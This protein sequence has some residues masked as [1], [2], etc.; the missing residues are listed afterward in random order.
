MK[1]FLL[2][3]FPAIALQ[4]WGIN[5]TYD[6]TSESNLLSMGFT[7]S[8]ITV[9]S[10]VY[11]QSKSLSDRYATMKYHYFCVGDL[12]SKSY[13]MLYLCSG[14]EVNER[15]PNIFWGGSVEWVAKEGYA[16][17]KVVVESTD[18][19][20]AQQVYIICGSNLS[21]IA[22]YTTEDA[23]TTCEF[24][25]EVRNF[26]VCG[27]LA[28][29]KRITVNYK[30]TDGPIGDVNGDNKVDIEDVNA[31]INI[32]LE[33]KQAS[34]YPGD[35][36]LN[37]DNKFDIEDVN[38]LINIILDV[39]TPDEPGVTTFTVNGVSFKMVDVEGG[40]FTMGATAEQGSDPDFWGEDMNFEKPVHQVT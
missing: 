37:G 26:A 22:T 23:I 9:D 40:T 8:E 31:A 15:W 17:S 25:D 6:Y 34:D 36:D 7:S 10:Y 24:S 29:I 38:A 30:Y 32:I 12:Q 35:A 21:E 4:S 2:L 3:L 39:A 11:N 18:S 28:F 20:A 33:M 19:G 1:K 14:D 13:T 5:V 16:V 27:D